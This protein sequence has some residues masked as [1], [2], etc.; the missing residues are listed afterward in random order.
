MHMSRDELAD[1][2]G[3]TPG[4][5]SQMAGSGLIHPDPDGYE[6]L[7]AFRDVVT[8]YRGLTDL[9]AIKQS[10]LKKEDELLE[11][12]LQKARGEVLPVAD[13][14]TVWGDIM[15][16][17][18]DALRRVGGKIAPMLPYAKTEADMQKRIE[19][20]IDEALREL[21]RPVDYGGEGTTIISR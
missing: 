5:I 4:R 14:Q 7:Q 20:A 15:L 16:K 10:K 17:V 13:V 9:S 1:I 21:S 6:V 8:Y 11:I 12:A 18:R 3:V 19:D 2:M